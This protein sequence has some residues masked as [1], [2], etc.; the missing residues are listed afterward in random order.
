MQL[1]LLLLSLFCADVCRMCY[2]AFMDSK[3]SY[4]FKSGIQCLTLELNWSHHIRNICCYQLIT[5]ELFF[6]I[7]FSDIFNLNQL[8]QKT[9]I[10]S[11]FC[12]K[13][14]GFW[15]I[16]QFLIS[17]LNE[18]L[19]FYI[20]CIINIRMIWRILNACRPYKKYLLR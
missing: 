16:F 4:K 14:V 13:F 1:L 7:N 17:F 6:S 18:Y 15:I 20:I 2:I 5:F 19:C 10:I 8:I 9:S 3:N 11:V 12:T